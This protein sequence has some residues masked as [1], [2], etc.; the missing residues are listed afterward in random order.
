MPTA[1]FTPGQLDIACNQG[2]DVEWSLNFTTSLTGYTGWTAKARY[3]ATLI[4]LTVDSSGQGSGIIVVKLTAAQNAAFTQAAWSLRVTD[5]S[6]H[7]K[8]L[9]AGTITC[10]TAP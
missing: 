2:D 6:A 9:L 4:T 5:P 7:P 8:T 10:E 1:D 3:G